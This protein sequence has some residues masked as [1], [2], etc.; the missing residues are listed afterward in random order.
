M[1]DLVLQTS[2]DLVLRMAHEVDPIRALIELIWNSIDAEA[3]VVRVLLTRS[4]ADAIEEVIVEDDGHGI[5]SDDIKSTFGQIGGSWKLLSTKT[6]NDRR[7][8]HG[9]R[10]EGRLRAFALGSEVSWTS[11]SVNT[12]GV[13]ETVSI[14]GSRANGRIFQ[15]NAVPSTASKTKTIFTAYNRQEKRLSALFG[16]SVMPKLRSHF[17]PVLLNEEN[18]SITF[19]GDSLD[20]HDEILHD[21]P[22]P[23]PLDDSSSA[24]IYLRIVEW[25]SGNHKAIYFGHDATHFTVE[26]P[27]ADVERQFPFS[28]YIYSD[29]FDTS[30]LEEL[31]TPNLAHGRVGAIWQSVCEAIRTHFA[32]RRLLRRREQIEQWRKDEV[33]PYT[34][35]PKSEP[36][37]VER[38]VFDV[39]ASAVVSKVPKR[40]SERRQ[41][42]ID[43]A[44][45]CC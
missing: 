24:T 9:K 40:A 19:D 20:P 22:L 3:D 11:E 25:K 18:L 16:D 32:A 44:T 33:Y 26:I 39:I 31:E 4:E 1:K 17:A 30:T 15:W 42:D 27:G 6:K 13:R 29:N 12:L 35:E 2:D 5:A 21:T 10:G 43:S 36:E 7:V 8:L 34:D 45:R 14:K 41:A 23:I 28:A 38:A 37:K